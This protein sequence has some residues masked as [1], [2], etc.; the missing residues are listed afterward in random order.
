[1]NKILLTLITISIL[2]SSM[3][4]LEP[5]KVAYYTTN[6]SFQQVHVEIKDY[7]SGTTLFVGENFNLTPNGSGVVIINIEDF[8]TGANGDLSGIDASTINT[9]VTVDIYVGT[10]LFSQQRLDQLIKM[11]SSTTVFDNSG[12]FTPPTTNSSLGQDDNRW[13]DAYVGSNTLHVG[14]DGG[15]TGSTEMTLSYDEIDNKGDISIDG[16]T[17]IELKTTGIT[18]PGL[19]GVGNRN[20]GVD[21]S[22][23]VVINNSAGVTAGDGLTLTTNTLDVG[24]SATIISNTDDVEVNS[25][26]TAN[27][28][29]LSSGTVGT[30]ATYG[31]LPLGDANAVSG[32]LPVANGG[33]GATTLATGNFLQGNG[34][35]AVTATKAIPTGTVVGTTD[36]Q[37]LTNKTID[38][39]NNT[40]TNIANADIKANAAIDATKLADG[41]VTSTELQYINS[42]TSNVQTQ[43]DAKQD[44]LPT[45]TGNSGKYLTTDG[46]ALSWGTVSGG[47]GVFTSTSGQTTI[48]NLTDDF[49]VGDA[50]MDHGGG[51]ETKMFYDDSKGAFRVG[52]INI[53]SWDEVSIGNYSMATGFNTKATGTGSITTGNE[54]IASGLNSTAMGNE[55]VA[56]G[57]YSV[58][59]GNTTIAD[60]GNSVAMGKYNDNTV[61]DE[62]LTIGNGTNNANRSNA[63]E[64]YDDGDVVVGNDLTV[65]N[66]AGGGTQNLQVDNTGKII[67]GGGG[68]AFTSAGGQTTINNLSDD[69]I[70]GHDSFDFTGTL[71]FDTETKMFFDDGKG[72][73]RA[74][75]VKND[76]WDNANIGD[77]STA[78]GRNTAASGRASTAM[79]VG[80]IANGDYSTAMGL[81]T[82]AIG[83]SSTAM[84]SGAEAIGSSSTAM[85]SGTE[86]K[87]KSSTAMGSSAKAIGT[88]STAMGSVTLARSYA[89]TVV[90]SYNTDYTPDNENDFDK[91]DRVFVVGNGFHNI[92]SIP[93]VTT[94]SDALIVY[95]S[96][97]TEINGNVTI[98]DD[99][100]ISN[101]AGGG[102]QNL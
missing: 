87:G 85:G 37:T 14:P 61:T 65:N 55:S 35:G 69:F 88:S 7:S 83:L 44:N 10:A 16:T 93:P 72:A 70:V 21:A 63:F 33:T 40:I 95:K 101:L 48:N 3:F 74:G 11:Q 2:A 91:D 60:A 90:G 67:T 79:G 57:L 75:E 20:I 97:D 15:M 58:A 41:S 96:G 59:I 17:A 53:D 68:G 43:L 42:V 102:T 29:L 26:G 50:T 51:T 86:A 78:F 66:L 47:S 76:N 23:N 18:I 8:P 24:G 25:S 31:A 52:G 13:E 32:T 81:N 4:A 6:T 98:E 89:E 84:G 22:G 82:E 77:Y 100:T 73:F 49:I 34:T 46:S 1:M 28:V 39:D 30:A 54:T 94:R 36:A 99:V 45:Q 62:L 27:Q 64:V 9:S 71:G 5:M 38:S 12:D 80:T 56:S 92:L 19:A